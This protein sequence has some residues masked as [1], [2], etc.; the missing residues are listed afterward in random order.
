MKQLLKSAWGKILSCCRD[1]RYDLRFFRELFLETK[2]SSIYDTALINLVQSKF[3][4]SAKYTVEY[5]KVAGVY[6][7]RITLNVSDGMIV[8]HFESPDEFV[9]FIKTHTL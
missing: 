1:L 4:R 8:R 7:M 5:S 6:R 9:E 3:G 2:F